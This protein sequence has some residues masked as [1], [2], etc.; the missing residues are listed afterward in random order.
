[1]KVRPPAVEWQFVCQWVKDRCSSDICHQTVWNTRT[2]AAGTGSGKLHLVI[3]K[4]IMVVGFRSSRSS[5]GP[6]V[7]IRRPE[8][9]DG[10]IY[11]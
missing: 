5:D 7:M 6:T 4:L 11:R 1:M 8:L 10:Q 9:L 2:L 3:P